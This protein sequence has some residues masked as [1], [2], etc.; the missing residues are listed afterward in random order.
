M[1][2]RY[3]VPGGVAIHD[4]AREAVQRALA[5]NERVEFEFNGMELSA[6]PG[7]SPA[8]IANR[9]DYICEQR[10][11]EREAWQARVRDATGTLVALAEALVDDGAAPASIRVGVEALR[12]ARASKP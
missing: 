12:R 8:D 10:S 5:S 11:R 7:D 6:A 4:A 3:E 2:R 1:A 9:Y